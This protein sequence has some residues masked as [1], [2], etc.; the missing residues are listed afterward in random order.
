MYENG[1]SRVNTI[2]GIQQFRYDSSQ[3][4]KTLRETAVCQFRSGLWLAAIL[5]VPLYA[6]ADAG[7][8]MLPIAYPVILIFLIPVIGIEAFT[9][10]QS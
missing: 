4:F 9:F 6:N 7:I 1:F 5:L 10:A 8:P 2:C 3:W